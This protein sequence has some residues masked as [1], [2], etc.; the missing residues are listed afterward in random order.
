MSLLLE[1]M[2]RTMDPLGGG[3]GSAAHLCMGFP[4]TD[5][6]T[7][8]YPAGGVILKRR[9]LYPTVEAWSYCGFARPDESTITSAE[10]FGHD[11]DQAYQYAAAQVLGNGYVSDFCEPVRVDFDGSGNLI[12]PGLPN[13]PLHLIA[14]P[15]SDRR[16]FLSFEYDPYGQGEPPTDFQVFEGATPGGVNYAA[17]LTDFATG[18]N[19]VPAVGNRR[20]YEFT[21][22]PFAVSTTHVFVVRARNSGGIAERNTFATPAKTVGAAQ[23][24]MTRLAP[25][26]APRPAQAILISLTAVAASLTK[27]ELARQVR[28]RP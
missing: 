25:Y 5:G 20:R 14:E 1:Q 4:I 8:P 21:T 2:L 15:I 13:A 17:P 19:Y 7:F 6:L 10:G 28:G 22:G 27:L 9:R 3:L 12:T 23:L 11:A 18:L 24:A 16:F 26:A